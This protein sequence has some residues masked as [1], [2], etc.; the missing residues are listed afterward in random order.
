MQTPLH[1][2]GSPLLRLL[3]RLLP[4][5]ILAATVLPA[6]A[7]P[8]RPVTLVVP[9]AAGG[10]NDVVARALAKELGSRW[11]QPVIVENVGGAGGLIGTNRVLNSA[12]DGH[13]ILVSNPALLILSYLHKGIDPMQALQPVGN[14]ANAP[15]VVVA[16]PGIRATDM[17]GLMEHCRS[18]REPCSVGTSDPL[19]RAYARSMLE[20]AQVTNAIS[21]NYRGTAPMV[22]DLRA[23]QIAIG[24]TTLSGPLPHHRS[25]GVRIVAVS[26]AGGRVPQVPDVPTFAEQGV[27]SVIPSVWT[28]AF[29]RREVP[30]PVLERL[31]AALQQALVSDELQKVLLT[32]GLVPAPGSAQAFGSQV[33]QQ[34]ASLREL[35]QRYPLA[36]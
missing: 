1:F 32:A 6:A 23:G 7:F 33:A 20:A 30:R 22:A 26:S 4:A 13:T 12:A 24:V 3:R 17:K 21:V 10:S 34:Q 8:T 9:F 11:S 19:S 2:S 14:I 25:G 18:A 31:S 16:A 36:E 28:G 29:V 15:A 35:L 5:A 27:N